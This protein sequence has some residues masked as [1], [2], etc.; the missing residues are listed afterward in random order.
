M[1]SLSLSSKDGPHS[2]IFPVA[3]A[4]S[5]A[6]SGA[7][8]SHAS[9]LSHDVHSGVCSDAMLRVLP[10]SSSSAAAAAAVVGSSS[11]PE[12]FA[13]PAGSQQQ[14]HFSSLS[15]PVINLAAGSGSGHSGGAAAASG[16]GQQD[17]FTVDCTPSLL[18]VGQVTSFPQNSPK[19]HQ[20]QN[21]NANN[22][23]SS[24]ATDSSSGVAAAPSAEERVRVDKR[25]GESSVVRSTPQQSRAESPRSLLGPGPGV[26]AS[27]VS[28]K[29]APERSGFRVGGESL[30]EGEHSSSHH[31]NNSNSISSHNNVSNSLAGISGHGASIFRTVGTSRRLA[32]GPGNNNNNNNN[33]GSKNSSRAMCSQVPSVRSS[34]GLPKSILFPL[35][36]QRSSVNF[37]N[38]VGTAR[39]E[40]GKDGGL[41][42]SR[43]FVWLDPLE[44]APSE[45]SISQHSSMLTTSRSKCSRVELFSRLASPAG[46][47]VGGYPSRQNS[48]EPFNSWSMLD[49][50]PDVYF[51]NHHN[52]TNNNTT[53]NDITP[54]S[55]A[56]FRL[57][58]SRMPALGG[59]AAAASS[60]KPPTNTSMASMK[61]VRFGALHSCA[62]TS[63]GGG[64]YGQLPNHASSSHPNND[65]SNMRQLSTLQ[66]QLAIIDFMELAGETSKR[67]ST[68][69][70]SSGVL[71][72]H[73]T[74]NVGDSIQCTIVPCLALPDQE[75]E[76][77]GEEEEEEGRN[78]PSGSSSLTDRGGKC[79]PNENGCSGGTVEAKVSNRS[80][81][82]REEEEQAVATEYIQQVVPLPG[83]GGRGC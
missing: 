57:Q 12:R 68:G 50:T 26:L 70:Y 21:S 3:A 15:T 59:A 7:L 69:G 49:A 53:L 80:E 33:N 36:A 6:P 19:L 38:R 27:V 52:T 67:N 9:L 46:G 23:F 14:P 58:F 16:S 82:D 77:W 54:A 44:M 34:I 5:S 29:S 76:A 10:P 31:H 83:G 17:G 51:S 24:F 71:H 41:V 61:G 18:S 78:H 47:G 22:T 64:L 4:S 60:D 55:S 75:E 37:S 56:S 81:G 62:S 1:L 32:D 42:S 79:R 35:D 39:S 30:S 11:I 63:G 45:R 13:F 8:D 25:F 65:L 20:Q 66:S 72:P 2:T 74:P 73:H 43:A 48:F 28:I 40:S